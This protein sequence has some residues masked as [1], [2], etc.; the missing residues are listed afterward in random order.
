MNDILKEKMDV[1][2]D[3]YLN[4]KDYYI[5][6]LED[7]LDVIDPN[8]INMKLSKTSFNKMFNNIYIK[9]LYIDGSSLD[10]ICGNKIVKMS[11]NTNVFKNISLSPETGDYFKIVTNNDK[12]VKNKQYLLSLSNNEIFVTLDF[13]SLESMIIRNNG[14]E[15]IEDDIYYG[16]L[17]KIKEELE[18]EKTVKENEFMSPEKDSGDGSLFHKETNSKPI[19]TPEEKVKTEPSEPSKEY[20]YLEIKE[21]YKIKINP[22]E[23]IEDNFNKVF[24]KNMS[25][26]ILSR[27]IRTINFIYSTTIKEVDLAV[28]LLNNRLNS[29]DETVIHAICILRDENTTY[30]LEIDADGGIK[31]TLDLVANVNDIVFYLHR[32]LRRNSLNNDLRERNNFRYKS[33]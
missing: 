30:V 11:F 3:Y 12:R 1:I 32:V 19:F 10:F 21:G 2:G 17:F 5:Y 22:F 28:Y 23:L 18:R 33:F 16:G 9:I 4:N 26:F 8:N 7:L 20:K 31:I 25:E 15:D 27:A 6:Q 24:T 29:L 14:Y 13:K